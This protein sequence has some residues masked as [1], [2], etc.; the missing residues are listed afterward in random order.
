MGNKKDREEYLNHEE[1]HF[2]NGTI[3]NSFR[4]IETS[5]E[6]SKERS[7]TIRSQFT[8]LEGGM[9]ARVLREV[10]D[11]SLAMIRG[12]RNEK[13]T[14]LF[15]NEPF[16]SKNTKLGLKCQD[17]I[18]GEDIRKLKSEETEKLRLLMLHI[19]MAL[20]GV[21][22]LFTTPLERHFLVTHLLT[23]PLVEFPRQ[24]RRLANFYKRKCA[25]S[26][27]TIGEIIQLESRSLL[28]QTA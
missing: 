27:K 11:E 4:D 25:D 1:Q 10:K 5:T 28:K 16:E 15:L 22:R 12:V 14:A 18:Y 17:F 2:I 20:P 7:K 13:D 26:G 19:S 8:T 3:F 6:T 21:Y 24:L 9:A 23:I